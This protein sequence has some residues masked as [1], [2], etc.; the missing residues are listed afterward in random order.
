[1][2]KAKCTKISNAIFS[3]NNEHLDQL[4]VSAVVRVFVFFQNSYVEI[5]MPS[6]MILEDGAFG[7]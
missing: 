1:M 7:R 3:I 4:N 2:K 6:V 5:L